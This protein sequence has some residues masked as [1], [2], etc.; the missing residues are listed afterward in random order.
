MVIDSI[1]EEEAKLLIKLA[2]EAIVKGVEGNTTRHIPDNELLPPRLQEPGATFVT[3]RKDGLLRGCI[4]TLEASLPLAEDVCEHA[5]AA[6]LHD[7]RFPPVS[8]EEIPH[9]EI[10]I[11]FLTRLMPI[12]YTSCE[13]LLSKIEPGDHGVVLRAGHRQATFL[14]QVWEIIPDPEEFM[15]RLCEK[16]RAPHNLWREGGVEVWVYQVVKFVESNIT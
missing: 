6:A 14:P 15:N 9:L 12:T 8:R 7:P 3:L 11:S 10:E 5:V 13:E 1:T 4:G 2:R 16:M